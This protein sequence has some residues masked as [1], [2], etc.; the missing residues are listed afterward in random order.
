M[1]TVEQYQKM[2]IQERRSRYFSLEFRKRK[3]SEIER[4]LVSVSEVAREYQ[5]SRTSIHRWIYKYSKMRKKQ[6]RQVVE[7]KSD[8]KKL[9]TLRKRIKDLEQM[10]GE[11]QAEVMIL[12]KMIDLTEEET[13]LDIKKKGQKRSSG[14]GSGKKS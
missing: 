10:L 3:V 12:N 13:G 5:V 7:S 2:T 11:K 8:T 14:T 4:N 1:A 6:E 9:E